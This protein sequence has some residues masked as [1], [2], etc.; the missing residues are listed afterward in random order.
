[1]IEIRP[2]ETLGGASHG[3]LDAKH[4]LSFGG[5]HDPARM[6]WGSLRV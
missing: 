4:H 6:N 3:W 1:M 2:F 5:Y